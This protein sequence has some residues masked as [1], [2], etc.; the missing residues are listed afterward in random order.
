MLCRRLETCDH[1]L[2][3]IDC[4]YSAV[5][6]KIL[7]MKQNIIGYNFKSICDFQLIKTKSPF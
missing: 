4:E 2:I 7:Q 5:K 3:R 1:K 6:T